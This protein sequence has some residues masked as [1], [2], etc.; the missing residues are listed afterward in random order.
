MG[1]EQEAF[2]TVAIPT[3]YGTLRVRAVNEGGVRFMAAMS[4][5]IPEVPVVRFH[6]SCVFGEALHAIDCDCGAQ[7]DAAQKLILEQG[8]VLIYAWEEGRG[9]GFAEK[10]RAIAL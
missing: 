8:G 2:P 4:E 9:V 1:D 7:L 5:T 10:V 3:P 6:S